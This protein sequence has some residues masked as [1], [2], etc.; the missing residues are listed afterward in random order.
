MCG[1]YRRTNS[2]EELARLYHIP[3]PKLMDLPITYKIA[4]SQNV[5]TIRFNA[6]S[7]KRSLDALWWR[8]IPYWAKDPKVAYRTINARAETIDKAPSFR[9]AFAKRRCLIPA[10]GFYE[11]GKTQRPKAAVR[12]RHERRTPVYLRRALG[13]LE[14][15]GFWRMAAHLYHYHRA[16]LMNSSRRSIPACELILP[17][18]HHAAWLGETDNGNLKMERTAGESAKAEIQ[19]GRAAKGQ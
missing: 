8:L 4:P 2:E 14:R 11:W 10:D 6:K 7:K 13:K 9:E 18:Q 16:G 3:I 17:E 19:S 5:L 1:R 15:S 12:D